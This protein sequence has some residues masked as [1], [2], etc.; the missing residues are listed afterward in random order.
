[1]LSALILVT[2]PVATPEFC[3]AHGYEYSVEPQAPNT[4]SILAL[5]CDGKFETVYF[6][7]ELVLK[8]SPEVI[9]WLKTGGFCRGV[10]MPPRF[11]KPAQ[12]GT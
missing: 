6:P 1:M 7:P 4:C 5:G 11:N 8:L 12:E 9:D 2:L 3:Q 10:P